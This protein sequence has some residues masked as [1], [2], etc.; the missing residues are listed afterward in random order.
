M[1]DQPPAGPQT[2]RPDWALTE[3]RFLEEMDQVPL[4]MKDLPDDTEDNVAIQALQ[5]L[6]FDG[7]PEEIAENFK[8]QGNEQF[9]GKNWKEAVK[10]YTQALDQKCEDQALNV[11]CYTNRAAANLELGNL[12]RVLTD[13][14]AALQLDPK[15]T[16]AYL[17]SARACRRLERYDE[18][19]D[20]CDRGL[21]VDGENGALKAERELAIN[22]KMAK[23]AKVRRAKDR[24]EAEK[25][26]MAQ[27]V[28][29][30]RLR[31]I[32]LSPKASSLPEDAPHRVRMDEESGHLLWP[33][34]FLYPESKETDLVAEW[35]ETSTFEDH[36]EAILAERPAWDTEG[37]Y[38]SPS[39]VEVFLED[40]AAGKLVRIRQANTLL[41][42]L[43]NERCVVENGVPAFLVLPKAGSFKQTFLAQYKP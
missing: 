41:K 9:S 29:A 27:L 13:C 39:E 35:D 34:L 16:K 37:R 10:F 2:V 43:M 8:N 17:R 21:R 15:S 1:S 19:K 36:L 23:E 7:T 18:A 38:G 11:A 40:K 12:R 5:A 22:A 30:I 3:E 20:A 25:L 26:R 33:V 32:R 14:A 4:F 24:E 6:A 31:G 28:E 42:V